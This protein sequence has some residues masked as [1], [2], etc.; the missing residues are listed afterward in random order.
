[1]LYRTPKSQ[2]KTCYYIGC[3]YR[4]PN[5]D[6]EDFKENLRQKLEFINSQGYEAYITG[7]INQDFFRYD[8][9]QQTKV[10]NK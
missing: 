10:K 7:D 9:D 2:A 1:M 8:T 4:H 5:S 3:I 6:R